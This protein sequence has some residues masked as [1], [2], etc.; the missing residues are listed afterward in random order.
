MIESTPTQVVERAS[1][2]AWVPSEPEDSP[3]APV[4]ILT[5]ALLLWLGLAAFAAAL[6]GTLFLVDESTR[7]A[8]ELLL[9]AGCGLAIVAWGRQAWIAPFGTYSQGHH[10]LRGNRRLLA[11]AV[12]IA[13]AAMALTGAD[14]WFSRHQQDTFGIAGWLWLGSMGLLVVA[15]A[16]WPHAV[17]V[18]GAAQVATQP[19]GRDHL[20]LPPWSPGEAG[21]FALIVA[22][23]FILRTWDLTNFPFAIHGDEII[24]GRV[25]TQSYMLGRNAPIFG[26]LW[27]FI[28]LPALWFRIIAWSLQL[29]DSTLAALR[30]PAAIFGA[31]TVIPLYG[32]LRSTWGRVAAIAGAAIMAFSAADVHYGRITLNNIVTQFFWAGCFFF[33]LRGLRTRHPVNWAA[34]GILAGLSEHF[35]YGT[36]L[37]PFVLIVFM[38]YL[39]VVHW[40]QAWRYLGH[41][42]VLA[43]GYVAGFGPLLVYFITHP[44]LYFGR[45]QGVL[46]WNH[47]PTSW[48]DLSLMWNA[49]W[50]LMSSNL[51]AVS[52]TSSGDPLYFAPLLFPVEA[53]LLALGVALLV[54]RWRQPAASLLLIS[55]FGVLFVGGTLV[56]SS[57]FFAHWTPAFPAI[58]AAIALPI[59]MLHRVSNGYLPDRFRRLVPLAL[60]LGLTLIG[61]INV[62]FYFN[63]YYAVRPEFEIAA[64]QARYEAG[65]GTNYMVF[66]VGETWQPYN[67]E[68]VNYLIKGQ[69]GTQVP[70]STV[71]TPLNNLGNKGLAFLFFGE[72][73]QFRSVVQ[74]LYPGGRAGQVLA[75]DGITHLFYTYE[76][77]PERMQQI[78]G[79]H[80]DLLDPVSGAVLWRGNVPMLGSLPAA[81]NFPTKARWSGALFVSEPGPYTFEI[82]GALGMLALDDQQVVFSDRR[83]LTIDWHNISLEM[84]LTE[85]T[86]IHLRFVR[87]NGVSAEIPTSRLWPT[88][89]R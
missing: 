30:L 40:R 28:D 20:A 85:P 51:L 54:W 33:L 86:D 58:Y 74:Q 49:L 35:Y 73:E 23:A 56:P 52:A 81:V 82:S 5:A 46:T 37:L 77:T 60:A 27:E 53:A 43:L 39:L 26:T 64:A 36:R 15:A 41:F 3:D 6:L 18:S 89:V 21:I 48:D 8:G 88:S 72:N 45:G 80:L 24:T 67:P 22:G 71:Q 29:G 7:T 55:G 32:L 68:M 44:G 65:L 9:V 57:A 84:L 83:T 70:A 50:P 76:V 66:N 63:R 69:V 4:R 47:I 14:Y 87:Q 1:I 2:T 61:I 10:R 17:D 13:I 78:Y 16:G 59:A 42:A 31:A 34:A 75:H 62:D 79:I 38:I 12:G 11:S 25:A 19:K